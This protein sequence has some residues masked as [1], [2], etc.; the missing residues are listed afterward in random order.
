MTRILIVDD[1]QA[2][3]NILTRML[4]AEFEVEIIEATNGLEALAELSRHPVSLV[5]LDVRMPIMDGVETLEAIRTSP[6]LSSLPVCIMTVDRKET[7]VLRTLQ[8]GV[9]DFILKPF[10]PRVALPRIRRLLALS[11]DPPACKRRAFSF[12]GDSQILIVDESDQFRGFFREQ[13]A[14]RCGIVDVRSGVEALQHCLE[15]APDAVFVGEHIGLL[16]RERLA[17]KIRELDDCRTAFLI[18]IAPFDSRPTRPPDGYDGVLVQTFDRSVFWAGITAAVRTH[19]TT[20]LSR[21]SALVRATVTAVQQACGLLLD[22]EVTSAPASPDSQRREWRGVRLTLDDK[23]VTTVLEY[24]MPVMVVRSG[25]G[26]QRGAASPHLFGEDDVATAISEI[27]TTAGRRLVA[28]F[29]AGGV[30]VEPGVTEPLPDWVNDRTD[31]A[32]DDGLVDAFATAFK[33]GE[34]ELCARL[35]LRQHAS[36]AV[37]L[38]TTT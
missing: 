11:S 2:N 38:K 26:R 37:A 1:D 15:R 3:R 16:D 30:A 29:M 18:A 4:E 19:E 14:A 12:D 32:A 22:L 10:N 33:S 35:I 28:A 17:R 6:E 20:L 5:L 24:A 27:A 21:D 34:G 36:E 7:L 25:L 23:R 31:S 13:V 9:E 8:L